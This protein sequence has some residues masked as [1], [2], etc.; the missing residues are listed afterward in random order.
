[1]CPSDWQATQSIFYTLE[2]WA[3]LKITHLLDPMHIFKNVGEQL[4]SHLVGEKETLATRKDLQVLNMNP[5][6]WPNT[7][8][9]SNEVTYEAAP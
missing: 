4:W 8:D 2:Y 3:T 9:T 7:S 5:N 1:M 6:I